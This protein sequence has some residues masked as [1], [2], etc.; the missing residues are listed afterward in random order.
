M[1]EGQFYQRAGYYGSKVNIYRTPILSF[2]NI[3]K[4][5]L[6]AQYTTPTRK[7]VYE[8]KPIYRS[9]R[10]QGKR[11]IQPSQSYYPTI[12]ESYQPD[13]SSYAPTSSQPRYR[14]DVSYPRETVYRRPTDYRRDVSYPRETVYRRPT[15][16]RRDVSYPPE[17]TYRREG[18]YRRDIGYD[19]DREYRRPSEYT[20]PPPK[21]EYARTIPPILPLRDKEKIRPTEAAGYDVYVKDRVYVKGKRKYQD[22][23]RKLSRHP[24]TQQRALSYG[25]HLVDHSAAATFYIKP[26]T[27]PARDPLLRFNSWE[28]QQQRFYSR[29]LKDE[30][31]IYIE[32]T[33]NRINTEGEIKGISALGWRSQMER[34]QNVDIQRDINKRANIEQGIFRTSTRSGTM[35]MNFIQDMDKMFRLI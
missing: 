9:D 7:P 2:Q 13:L 1:T 30:T 16:Y 18:E 27:K 22:R 3:F 5:G 26:T 15:D 25:A 4:S 28:T 10:S 19:Y 14:R 12:T 20:K 29:K 21:P 17:R 6:I 33:Q 34:S 23:Y 31:V 32:K 24:M 11:L 8:S 35:G